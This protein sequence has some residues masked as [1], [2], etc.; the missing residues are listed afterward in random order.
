MLISTQDMAKLNRS[1]AI[2]RP[3]M[4]QCLAAG[5]YIAHREAESDEL[6][7][8]AAHV[9]ECIHRI[10]LTLRSQGPSLGEPESF[11]ESVSPDTIQFHS[12]CQFSWSIFAMV[13]THA[14]PSACG[15]SRR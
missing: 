8:F 2:S 5:S 4:V 6:R 7:P 14:L 10:R 15:H 1:I 13:P 9:T 3:C 11:P 12:T